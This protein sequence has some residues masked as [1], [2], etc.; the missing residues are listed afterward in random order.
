[1]VLPPFTGEPPDLSKGKSYL[2]IWDTGATNSIISPDIIKELGL[3]PSGKS[4]ANGVN[5]SKEVNTYLVEMILPN[6]VRL[7]PFI[8]SEST[9]ASPPNI[10][11]DGLIGMDVINIGDFCISNHGGKTLFT[12][13]FP[14]FPNKTD[15]HLLAEEHNKSE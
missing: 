9:V 5:S 13:V 4:I 15:L 12:F 1:M 7:M 8:V 6:N 10:K 3:Q 14:P 11:I 2:F